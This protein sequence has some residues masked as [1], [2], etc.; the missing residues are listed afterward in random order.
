MAKRIT[1]FLLVFCSV[2]AL[3]PAAAVAADSRKNLASDLNDVFSVSLYV[4]ADPDAGLEADV[5]VTFSTTVSDAALYLPGG[6]DTNR[7]FLS[8]EEINLSEVPI[9]RKSDRV[10]FPIPSL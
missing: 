2:L 9:C 5:R 4:K 7:L 10:R 8:E 1:A 6:T 3:L